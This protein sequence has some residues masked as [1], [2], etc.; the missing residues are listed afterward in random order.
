M[1]EREPKNTVLAGVD[2]RQSESLY[3]GLDKYL[4]Y[5]RIEGSTDATIHHKK[6][7]LTAFLR[8]L[9]KERAL[10]P[11]ELGLF[12][13]L[14]HLESLKERGL[15]PATLNTR[16]RA[17]HAWCQ[18]MTDW[19]IIPVNPA[20]KLKAPK[21]PKIRKGFISEAAFNKLLDISPLNTMLG[22]RRQAMLWLLSTTGIRRREL[23]MLK[24]RDLD[25]E[26]GEIRVIHGKGQKERQIPFLKE[27]QQ[28]MYRYLH[29]RPGNSDWLWVGQHGKPLQYHSLGWEFKKLT[30]RAGVAD[31]IQDPF[32]IFR[33]T[34]AAEA[35]RQG[36]PRPYIQAMLGWATP[37]MLDKYIAEM[38]NESQAID[39]FKATF[40]PFGGVNKKRRGE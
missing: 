38:E 18:W 9:E 10:D 32:H 19:E 29:Q 15:A 13:I 35:V 3:K 26:A 17:I 16:Y 4:R 23:L 6:K 33:R 27:A 39:V 22:A 37:Q 8:W 25:W 11:L 40:K 34:M 21:M 28:P 7:E 31:E 30:Q 36:V 12:D 1:V 20:S 24:V 14:A 2:T 5:H